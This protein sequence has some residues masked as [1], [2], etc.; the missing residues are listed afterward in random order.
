[1]NTLALYDQ[2]NNFTHTSD[3]SPNE[4][5]LESYVK[6]HFCPPLPERS[7]PSRP[8]MKRANQDIIKLVQDPSKRLI[9]NCLTSSSIAPVSVSTHPPPCQL[10]PDHLSEEGKPVVSIHYNIISTHETK[11][12][13]LAKSCFCLHDFSA[14]VCMD[15]VSRQAKGRGS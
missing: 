8:E 5:A 7:Q 1:M 11:G 14:A 3:P 10:G 4:A 13:L 2:F 12:R 15:F 6:S 9:P